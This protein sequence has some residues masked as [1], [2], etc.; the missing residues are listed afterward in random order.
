MKDG[1]FSS[2]IIEE[3]IETLFV[4]KKYED[5][6]QYFEKNPSFMYGAD[7]MLL[8]LKNVVEFSGAKIVS[9]TDDGISLGFARICRDNI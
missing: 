3:L 2:D 4:N 5:L 8:I 9:P 7:K 1:S 6:F